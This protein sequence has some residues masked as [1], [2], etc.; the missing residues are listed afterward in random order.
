MGRKPKGRAP[1]GFQ[2]SDQGTLVHHP[3]NAPVVRLIFDLFIEHRV[4]SKVAE[5]LNGMGHKTANGSDWTEVQIDRVLRHT[6]ARGFHA[7]TPA[8]CFTPFGSP[9]TSGATTLPWVPGK[10]SC[11]RGTR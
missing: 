8:E 5:L 6:S 10:S 11:P 2:F 1:F 4:K 3:E 7:T 9:P